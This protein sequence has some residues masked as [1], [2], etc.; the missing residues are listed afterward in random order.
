MKASNS[1]YQLIR[2]YNKKRGNVKYFYKGIVKLIPLK[3]IFPNLPNLSYCPNSRGFL[4]KKR[5]TK[6]PYNQTWKT[7][8]I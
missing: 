8:L 4:I 7:S 6:G 5:T 3:G 1:N 2:V